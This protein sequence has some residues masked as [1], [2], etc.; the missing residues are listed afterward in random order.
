MKKDQIRSPLRSVSS[1]RRSVRKL[2]CTVDEAIG[3]ILEIVRP[4]NILRNP[5][6]DIYFRDDRPG[7]PHARHTNGNW[8]S[9][10]CFPGKVLMEEWRAY[11][12]TKRPGTDWSMAALDIRVWPDGRTM[13]ICNPANHIGNMIVE[14]SDAREG[15]KAE[16]G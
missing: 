4:T 10:R 11:G 3:E 5:D 2:D 8:I 6:A 13:I 9:Y 14:C 1:V 15:A 16:E 7:Y 12:Y